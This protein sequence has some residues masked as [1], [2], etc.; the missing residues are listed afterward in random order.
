[1]NIRK[2]TSVL[3]SILFISG[4]PITAEQISKAM[5]LSREEVERGL[6]E[7]VKKYRDTDS[8][9]NL[10]LKGDFVQLVTCAN[11]AEY[12]DKFSKSA[13]QESLSKAALEVLS[14]I[15]YRGP[16]SRAEIEAIRGVNCSVTLRNLLIRELVE[17][18]ENKDD[19]RGYVYSV[20][21]QFLKEIGLQKISDLPDYD[22][23]SADERL[24]AV[25]SDQQDKNQQE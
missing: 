19:A 1:M 7:L 9:L 23:L 13:M 2:I 10:V 4:E 18:T 6:E 24:N 11:N 25:L 12:I 14:V 21:L 3:E 17:R 5:D 16:L 20:S 8:G 22:A 15:A